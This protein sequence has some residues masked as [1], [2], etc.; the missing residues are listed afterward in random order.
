MALKQVGKPNI[1]KDAVGICP[2]LEG[3]IMPSALYGSCSICY[4]K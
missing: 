2:L 3:D 1:R 4:N